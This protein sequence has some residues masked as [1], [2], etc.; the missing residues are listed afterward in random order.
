M[1]A[2]LIRFPPRRGRAVWLLQAREGGWLVL[3]GPHGWL[4]GSRSAALVDAV[5][6]AHNSGFHRIMIA[7]G[8]RA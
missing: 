6:H 3:H 5:W 7:Y 2:A 8:G 1:T 4:H